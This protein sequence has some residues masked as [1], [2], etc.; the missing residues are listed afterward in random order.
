MTRLNTSS[1]SDPDNSV[2]SPKGM[3]WKW[4]LALTASV[5]ILITWQCRS[6]LRQGRTLADPA[7]QDFHRELNEGQYEQ[8]YRAADSGLAGEGR[9][10]ALIKF[11]EGVHTKLGEAGVARQLSIRVSATTFGSSIIAQ[12]DT[13]YTRGSAIETFTWVKK[14][15]N[16][17]LHG[18]DIRS[19]A[20]VAY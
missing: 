8:I 2:T 9:H 3:L 6:A 19:N 16:L 11:L 10:D 15:G 1:T 7:V 20:L 13:T 12:Y 18:Y 4:S 17:K 5:F 14:D